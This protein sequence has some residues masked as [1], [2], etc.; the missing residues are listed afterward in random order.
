MGVIDDCVR[1]FDNSNLYEVLGTERT[2]DDTALKRAYHKCALKE[3]PDRGGN[4]EKFQVLSRV[5]HTLANAEHRAVYDET[6][7]VADDD[8]PFSDRPPNQ[9]WADYFSE[10][11]QDVTTDLLDADKKNYQGSAEERGDVKAAYEKHKGDLT[12][13]VE[14]IMHST[15]LDDEERFRTMIQEM[16]DA[17]E[18]TSLPKFTQEPAKVSKERRRKAKKEA[19]EAEKA[20]REIQA[21]NTAKKTKGGHAGKAKAG[22]PLDIT[23]MIRANQSKRGATFGSIFDKFGVPADGAPPDIPDEAFAAVGARNGSGGGGRKK[24]T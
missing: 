23:A 21:K 19:A 9:T 18:L 14:N 3:H 8:D 4:T 1:L 10:R 6:G 2:A 17:G 15:V 12:A 24:K 11:F 22:G 13:I 16:I 5:Y 7:A 20:L